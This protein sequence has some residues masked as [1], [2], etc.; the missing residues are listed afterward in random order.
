MAEV[1]L[2]V[3]TGAAE[4][5]ARPVVIKRLHP[6]LGKDEAVAK[7][8]LTEARLAMALQHQNLV[9]VLDVGREPEGTYRVLELVN[10]WDLSLVIRHAQRQGGAPEALVAHLGSQVAA[11]L[12]SAF[13]RT[14]DGRPLLEAHGALC[15]SNILVSADGEVK[16]A[17][18]GMARV[19][20]LL[21]TEPAAHPGKAASSAPEVVRGGEPT[22]RSDQFS[23]G[24]VLYQL[25]GKGHP[26]GGGEEHGRGPKPL[27]GK[28]PLRLDL[29][30]AP[31]ARLLQ[32]LLSVRP[33][34][35]FESW[36]DVSRAFTSTAAQSGQPAGPDILG[37]WL[38]TLGLPPPPL[39]AG[40]LVPPDAPPGDGLELDD[41]W[42]PQGPTLDLEGRLSAPPPPSPL[43]ATP[44]HAKH[45][46]PALELARPLPLAREAPA[47]TSPE[48]FGPP[49]YRQEPPPPKRRF[50][51]AA[52]GCFVVLIALAAG[53]VVWLPRGGVPKLPS[54]G[55]HEPSVLHVQSVPDGAT[56]F[57]G[58]QNLG[59]TPLAQE[60]TWAPGAEIPV[61][62]TLPGHEPWTGT[63]RGGEDVTLEAK[64]KKR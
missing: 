52:L 48:S 1:H 47:S 45:E 41:R 53:A 10:G 23:L 56:V 29:D 39:D 19:Q 3:P 13:R 5:F 25:L 2:A 4:G 16:V 12:A 26:D 38:S 58:G 31:L 20:Q 34:D 59:K 51:P 18:F 50:F 61:R 37:S 9:Q 33:E 49:E 62:L 8:F 15:A 24:V 7:R 28:G 55:R 42:K 11:G 60:N 46:E 43:R 30:L 27:A 63:L 6:H 64:L 35:R 21:A 22:Q 54:F 32:R 57:V 14:R 36:D 40:H 17:D 44:S